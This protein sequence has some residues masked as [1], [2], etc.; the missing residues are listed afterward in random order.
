MVWS[1]GYSKRRLRNKISSHSSNSGSLW[2]GLSVPG[3]LYNGKLAIS[4]DPLEGG[5]TT[6]Y[7]ACY[8]TNHNAHKNTKGEKYK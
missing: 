1:L 2:E 3:T 4:Q 8:L 5:V 7:W 6:K